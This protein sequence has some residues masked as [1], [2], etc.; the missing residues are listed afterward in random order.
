MTSLG[1][2]VAVKVTSCPNSTHA[3]SN[4]LFMRSIPS[5]QMSIP[6]FLGHM[7]HLPGDFVVYQPRRCDR[8]RTERKER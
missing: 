5:A 3:I 6:L 8:H 7:N 1:D 4:L 2:N